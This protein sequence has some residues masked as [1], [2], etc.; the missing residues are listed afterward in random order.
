MTPLLCILA[1][2]LQEAPDSKVRE[3][4]LE[5]RQEC[6]AALESVD[7]VLS[8]GVGGSGADY[9]LLIVVRDALSQHQVRE[10]IGTDTYGG[11]RIVWSIAAAP[12]PPAA[13]APPPQ[14]VEKPRAPQA[15]PFPEAPN[16]WDARATDCDIIRDY[17][18][19]KRV[20]H[21]AGNGRSWTP[22]Q[23]MNRTTIGP[24]GGHA[25]TYTDHRP[26]CPIR[27]G[28]VAEP[29]WTDNYIAWV[30]RQG[31]TAPAPTTMT[32]PGNPWD[33]AAQAGADMGSR[34]PNLRAGVTAGPTWVAGPGWMAPLVPVYAPP[35][36]YPHRYWG[37]RP[38]WHGWAWRWRCWR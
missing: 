10:Y 21:P 11:L 24:G 33:W 30:F 13:E 20:T 32:L 27:L 8:V 15:A 31:I 28:R 1:L 16:F 5:L 37:W 3:R 25:F 14:P 19:L 17:L 35:Y 12:R 23:V 18:K 9:R 7:G 22:C 36:S 29:P 6:A 4:A 34:I 38:C 26:D 2:A